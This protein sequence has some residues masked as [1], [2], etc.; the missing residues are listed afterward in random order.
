MADR[1]SA[2]AVLLAVSAYSPG[3]VV[4][5]ERLGYRVERDAVYL[6]ASPHSRPPIV[7]TRRF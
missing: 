7:L 3:L 2:T 6:H 4:W 1:R 5:Y